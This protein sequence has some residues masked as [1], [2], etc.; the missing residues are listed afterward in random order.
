[1]GMTKS[2]QLMVNGES[3]YLFVEMVIGTSSLFLLLSHI[4]PVFV[5]FSV[6]QLRNKRLQCLFALYLTFF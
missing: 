4:Y 1:M 5:M 3:I 2:D 6:T